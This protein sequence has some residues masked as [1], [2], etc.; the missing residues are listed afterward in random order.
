[1]ATTRASYGRRVLT[2]LSVPRALQTLCSAAMCSRMQWHSCDSP[3]LAS[4]RI[5]VEDMNF[6]SNAALAFSQHEWLYSAV[7]CAL[8]GC[9]TSHRKVSGAGAEAGDRKAIAWCGPAQGAIGFTCLQCKALLIVDCMVTV[10]ECRQIWAIKHLLPR[11]AR[12]VKT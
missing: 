10:A 4:W 2:S 9:C 1:M 3:P 6:L 5:E 7:A 8:H 12:A 11:E